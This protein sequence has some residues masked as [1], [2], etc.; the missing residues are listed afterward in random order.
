MGSARSTINVDGAQSVQVRLQKGDWPH[1]DHLVGGQ[2]HG[3]LDFCEGGL[4][5]GQ[6]AVAPPTV[7]M[8]TQPV[9]PASAAPGS[10]PAR[11]YFRGAAGQR[12]SGAAGQWGSGVRHLNSLGS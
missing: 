1:G 6:P 10:G 7:V 3:A 8:P 11:E 9:V 5:E 12:G 2:P 4:D